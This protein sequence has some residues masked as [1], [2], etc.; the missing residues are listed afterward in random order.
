MLVTL[1]R[2]DNTRTFMPR[3]VTAPPGKWTPLWSVVKSVGRVQSSALVHRMPVSEVLVPN[4][5]FQ[6]LV[7]EEVDL[8]QIVEVLE[9]E[10]VEMN[11]RGPDLL[12]KDR[13]FLDQLAG[14]KQ[15]S[16]GHDE[17]SFPAKKENLRLL[18]NWP[19]AEDRLEQVNRRL[20]RHFRNNMSLDQNNDGP[21]DK[22]W[23]CGRSTRSI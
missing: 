22:M 11:T 19:Q 15:L 9:V 6:R 1:D 23:I 5:A 10:F 13:K 7:K 21:S 16:E 3:D 4:S 20:L 2:V 17:V 18:I 8:W 14:T 12:H